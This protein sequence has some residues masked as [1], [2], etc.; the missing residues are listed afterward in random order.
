[1]SNLLKPQKLY[2]HEDAD[3]AIIKGEYFNPLVDKVNELSNE[4]GVVNA[5]TVSEKTAGSG[6]TVD[7][8]LLKDG[9]V[10]MLTQT[11]AAIGTTQ[12]TGSQIAGQLV[13]VTGADAT[14]GVVLPAV[15]N[16]TVIFLIN[17][18]NAILKVYPASGEKILG[19]TVNVN[20]S[21]AAYGVSIFGYKAAGDWYTTEITGGAV[22]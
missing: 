8:V 19:G 15:A 20:I 11:L 1:M 13:F 12:A 10:S 7:S 17:T 2:K 22:A 14:K 21:L 16:G 3:Y 4:E 5:D 18:A 6:V 9:T